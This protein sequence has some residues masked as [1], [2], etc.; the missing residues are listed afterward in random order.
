MFTLGLGTSFRLVPIMSFMSVAAM[1]ADVAK[2][3]TVFIYQKPEVLDFTTSGKAEV[4]V[5]G[6]EG[7]EV[8]V[9]LDKENVLVLWSI[10]QFSIFGA[11][12]KVIGWNLKSLFSYL[13]YYGG[14][15]FKAE[16]A[17]IDLKIIESYL[18]IA[19][20]APD[21]LAQA[22]GRVRA[23]FNSGLWDGVQKVYKRI[24]L[25]L[26]T[27]VIPA[28]E[29]RRLL[30]L[31][32]QS[33]V[34]AHYQIDGQ[35]N[36]RLK[37]D[38][39]FALGFVPH[40][41]SAEDR[42]NITPPGLDEIFLYFDFKNM[43]VAMLQWLS[44][45]ERLG[46]ILKSAPDFYTAVFEIVVGKKCEDRDIAKKFFL[47]TIYGQSPNALA[48][49]L[50]IAFDTAQAI[51]SRVYD[52][53]PQATGWVDNIQGEVEVHRTAKDYFGR[54]R[55]FPDK[56]YLVRNF[57]V[58]APASII[59]LD[60]LI[61]L[62]RSVNV[63][64]HIHDGYVVLATKATWQSAYKTAKEILESESDL[65]PGLGLK[66]NCKAGRSL[67]KLK[68]IGRKASNEDSIRGVPDS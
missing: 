2:G 8:R 26:L 38:K 9:S 13:R 41:L 20:L 12:R 3:Q 51:V 29:T 16:G 37:C 42:E 24:H 47:P 15:D 17:L 43:E 55:E 10:L 7:N 32:L 59:C 49:K 21:S 46:E 6:Q 45:D 35:E 63:A 33:P 57:V 44:G 30:D 65:C 19:K 60:K 54:R 40:A 68:T 64:F 22:L 14:K 39:A 66:V 36:G 61:H 11:G 67:G 56:A 48:E 1:L 58:Q 27:T 28:L 34:H 52:L 50:N 5:C 31:R 25:P 4:V 53:F 18:G 23:I 62:H